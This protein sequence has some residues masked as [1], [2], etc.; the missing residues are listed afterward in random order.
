MRDDEK[1]PWDEDTWKQ[2]LERGEFS[3]DKGAKAKRPSSKSKKRGLFGK[4]KDDDDDAPA[5]P[6]IVGGFAFL[7][8]L[9]ALLPTGIVTVLLSAT[10]FRL[11]SINP[12]GVFVG[13]TALGALA[14]HFFV[15]AQL[16]VFLHEFKHSFVSSLV[17]NK[18]K[19]M[20][21]DQE[22][23]HFE[24]SYTK[25]TSHYNAFISL[26]PYIVPVLTL[27][28][29]LFAFAGFRHHHEMAVLIVGIAY[30]ADVL[31]GLRDISP[32]QTDIT[33]IRGGYRVGLLYI[34]AWQLAILGVL[35]AWV[36]NGIPGLALLIEAFSLFFIKLH[37]FLRGVPGEG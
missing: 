27:V 15:R 12:S 36:F 32:I 13:A 10:T 23:G 1:D 24:Y 19:G 18:W 9:S 8:S 29:A 33:L 34:T 30:G 2:T 20:K 5:E 28:A 3:A 35:L 26:A 14:A 4:H 7:L 21:V 6:T 11:E 25:D 22:S 17:G 31:L 37:A 16:S